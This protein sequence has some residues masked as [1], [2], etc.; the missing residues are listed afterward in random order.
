VRLLRR[1]R[2]LAVLALQ[3]IVLGLL[4][5]GALGTSHTSLAGGTP[6]LAVAT[7]AAHDTSVALKDAPDIP[8]DPNRKIPEL[9]R[10]TP[11]GVAAS[12]HDP[13]LQA[14]AVAPSIAATTSTFAGIRMSDLAAQWVPPDTVGDVGESQ[15]VQAVNGGIDVFAKNG[16]NLSGAITDDSFWN[17]FAHCGGAPRS[18]PT[19]NYDEYAKRWVYTEITT[20]SPYYICAAV[21]TTDDATDAWYRYAFDMGT[22]LPDYQ[23]LGVWPDGYYLSFNNFTNGST[24]RG[25]GVLAL[26][27]SQ[28]LTG[29]SAQSVYFDLANVQ[30]MPFGALPSDADGAT[31]PP[32]NAPNYFAVPNDDPTAANNDQLGVWAFHVD[33]SA[34]GGSTFTNVQNLNVSAFDGQG[35]SVPQPPGGSNLDGLANDQLMNRLQYRNFGGYETLVVNETVDNSG[36]DEPRWYELRRAAGTW[37]VNQ[38]GTFAPDSVNR[39]M[40]SAAMNGLGDMALGYS[41]ADASTNPALRFTG[42]LST[43]LLG[44][45]QAENVLQAGGGVQTG[46]TRW[47]DYSQMSVDPA[48]DCTF[49]FTGEYYTGPAAIDWATR[50]ASIRIGTC[51]G[52]TGPTYSVVPT[53]SG[54]ATEGQTLSTTAGTWSPAP[55]ST[56]YQW[57]RCDSN[58]L[59]CTDIASATGSTYTL[60]AA[61]AG[62]RVRVKVTVTSGAAGT[63]SVVS[64]STATILPLA[65]VNAGVPAITGT[66]QLGQT[67]VATTGTWT[68]ALTPAYAYQWQR[69]APACVDISG[70][71]GSSY[72]LT[73]PGDVGSTLKV[74]VTATNTGGSATATS[75]ATSAVL[76]APAPVNTVLPVISGT[77][78]AATTL[79]VGTGTWTGV[80]PINYSYQ[81]QTC[82]SSGVSCVP[83]AG[84]TSTAYAVQNS[85]VGNR[86]RV[87]VTGTN[88]GGAN[89]VNTAVTS[90]VVPQPPVSTASPTISGTAAV[91][92]TLT[93]TSSGTWTGYAPITYAYSWQSCDASGA[94][95]S[96]IGGASTNSY[97]VASSDQG[98]TIRGAVI[99]TNGGGSRTA[100]STA[101]SVVPTVSGGSGGSGG[102]AGSGGSSGGGGGAGSPDLVV[103]GLASTA[104]PLPGDNVLYLL[105]VT[106]KNLKPAQGIVLTVSLPSGLQYVSSLT[107]RG[108]GCV[109]ATSSTLNC[110]LDWLSA[111]VATANIQIVAKVIATGQ[112]MLSA[113][114]SAQQGEANSADNTL[115]IAINGTSATTAGSGTVPAGLNGDGTPT[116]KQDKKKPNVSALSSSAKRGAVAKLRFKIY[117]DQG[118]A[119]A[120]TTIKRSG[121]KVAVSNTGFGPV[122]YGSVYYTGWKVPV[123]APKGNYS[124][125]VVGV[126]SAGNKSAQSCAPL[127][128]K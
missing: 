119:K 67:L 111:D 37:S 93:I 95:C 53:I 15:Y 38:Q 94:N 83:L 25:V 117:D 44:S 33:W 20:S 102:S 112:Q 63:S 43:D 4:A 84:Q 69:C 118:V 11:A 6:Q 18:D 54:T 7:D 51:T 50:I 26:E 109:L 48:D 56:T 110:N 36:Q 60:L 76:Q 116:K 62:K 52:P 81:W 9:E 55:T 88:S 57:R 73:N 77:A 24:Y 70:A 100:A 19:V 82:S 127:A 92:Q 41:A 85:D 115:A 65:P 14:A 32:A 17:G 105:A 107:D 80:A 39:W 91:G 5:T 29:A 101:S 120:L 113:T 45:M 10:Q 123:H 79:N 42:R 34:P 47:G 103:T 31:Q 75:A 1:P 125:C 128:I 97:T 22:V 122:A 27:R 121:K 99:A 49:W 35:L 96:T 74:K 21:S 61:D 98:K 23:K 126:D 64:S 68:S 30:T 108:N 78:M 66:A 72:S 8:L 16:G 106:D 86:L 104:T 58:G 46:S 124:F 40:G 28:M 114:A 71:N 12:P 87:V 59:F 89:S 2:L 13:V 3:A 90:V